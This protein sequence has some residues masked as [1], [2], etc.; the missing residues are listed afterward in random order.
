MRCPSSKLQ[1]LNEGPSVARHNWVE[2][3]P[4]FINKLKGLKKLRLN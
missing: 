2:W 1:S 4:N 3:R